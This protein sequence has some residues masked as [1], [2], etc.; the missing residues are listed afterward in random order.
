MIRPAG[1]VVAGLLMF[2][3]FISVSCDVPGGYGRAAPGGT[4]QYSGVDLI[5]GGE[6]GVDPPDKLREGDS[7]RI[8]PQPLAI[9]TVLLL[10]AGIV[11][12]LRVGHTLSRRAAIALL[13][14]VAAICLVVN[15]ITVQTLLFERV[16]SKYVHNQPGFWL[17]L[18]TLVVVMF[19]NAIGWLRAAGRSSHHEG[20]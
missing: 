11:I 14:G 3:P 10:I 17:C 5:V 20:G 19:A 2:L 18:S 4:T 8:A 9:L 7:G 13:S 15:Q 16:P 6:P 1:F 12:A